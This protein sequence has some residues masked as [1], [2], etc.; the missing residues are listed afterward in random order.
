MLLGISDSSQTSV[1]VAMCLAMLSQLLQHLIEK[2]QQFFSK[3]SPGVFLNES[4]K[5]S[6]CESKPQTARNDKY[7]KNS[8]L[9]K[10][11]NQTNG[12]VNKKNPKFLE[13][14]RSKFVY[15]ENK[16]S[17][18]VH[19]YSELTVNDLEETKKEIIKKKSKLKRRKRVRPIS[20]CESDLSDSDFTLNDSSTDDESFSGDSDSEEII[21]SESEDLDETLLI[22]DQKIKEKKIKDETKGNQTNG[23][24]NAI[25][26]LNENKSNL[27][28]TN[29][30]KSTND[31]NTLEKEI[32]KNGNSDQNGMKLINEKD[33]TKSLFTIVNGVEEDVKLNENNR[34]DFTL[35]ESTIGSDTANENTS[36]SATNGSECG[37]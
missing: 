14:K 18:R 13:K 19:E 15:K 21:S 35:D 31:I 36:E 34:G 32:T 22:I 1:V 10:F 3:C 27:M 23:I 7:K 25:N 6:S 30:L 29:L 28:G 37:E 2:F 17:D 24:N 16:N 26:S 20:S 5:S 12:N 9:E 4:Q 33:K 11:E 8:K